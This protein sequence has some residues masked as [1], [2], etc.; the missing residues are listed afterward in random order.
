M[1]FS[2]AANKQQSQATAF[3]LAAHQRQVRQAL[4]RDARAVVVHVNDSLLAVAVQ[5]HTD[6]RAFLAD[7]R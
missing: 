2:S 3:G 4:S 5:G 7:D 1:A 6:G